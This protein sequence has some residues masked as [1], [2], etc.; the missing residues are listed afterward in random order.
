M[1]LVYNNAKIAVYEMI[2]TNFEDRKITK[3]KLVKSKA[4]NKFQNISEPDSISK[5]TT[6]YVKCIYKIENQTMILFNNLST[7]LTKTEN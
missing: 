4:L 6:K 5:G 2:I 3:F 7:I 1:T